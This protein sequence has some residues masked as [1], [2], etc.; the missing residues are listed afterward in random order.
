MMFFLAFSKSQM[1]VGGAAVYRTMTACAVSQHGTR[2]PLGVIG[3]T[4][5]AVPISGKRMALEA[6][7]RLRNGKQLLVRCAMRVVAVGAIFRR[8]GMFESMRPT[9]RLV[10][11]GAL[12]G[13]C[14]E[15]GLLRGMRVMA[16]GT[17]GAAFLD[18]VVRGHAELGQHILVAGCAERG[19]FAAFLHS[20]T[21]R[22]DLGRVIAM[23]VTALDAGLVVLGDGEVHATLVALVTAETLSRFG[24]ADLDGF[25]L[26]RLRMFFH[27]IVAGC[28]VVMVGV[29]YRLSLVAFNALAA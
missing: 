13:F 27:V 25:R 17:G 24:L 8:R 20:R 28:A 15:R 11:L 2:Y 5:L 21:E 19:R 9:H 10:A 22:F 16:A 26:G 3:C 6:L 29:G 18:R 7:H 4:A 23:A 12:R 14:A 1:L